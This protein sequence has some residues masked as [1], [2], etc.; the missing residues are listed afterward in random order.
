MSLCSSPHQPGWMYRRDQVHAEV[1]HDLV[2]HAG[3]TLSEL[4]GL[5]LSEVADHR[6]WQLQDEMEAL[7]AQIRKQSHKRLHSASTS[8]QYPLARY[9][10]LFASKA[11][12]LHNALVQAQTKRRLKLT[13]RFRALCGT[14]MLF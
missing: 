5:S 1:L 12:A 9:A 11:Q 13:G 4:V 8:S 14:W 6:I 3:L 7:A 2:Q 10:R